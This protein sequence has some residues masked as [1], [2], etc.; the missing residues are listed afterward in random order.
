MVNTKGNPARG[1]TSD[2]AAAT[3]EVT[4]DRDGAMVAR[5]STKSP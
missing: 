5:I 1:A 3:A 4:R 2:A